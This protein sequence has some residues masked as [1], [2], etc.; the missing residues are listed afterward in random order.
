MRRLGKRIKKG[1]GVSFLGV[2]FCLAGVL[3]ILN[4]TTFAA[5]CENGV[6]TSVL[7][8][9]GCYEVG[10]EGEAI[11]DILELVVNVLTFGVGAAGVLGIVISGVQYMTA[12]GNE[13][14]MTKAKNRIVEVIIGLVAYSVMYVFLQWLIPGGMF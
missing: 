8:G 1:V 10:N 12:G 4:R 2:V 14:Q 7:G 3:G 13:T 11:Y 6:E 9:E 5:E